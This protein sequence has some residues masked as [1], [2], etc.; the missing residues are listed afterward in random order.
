MALPDD[1]EL[2]GDLCR[3]RMWK[4]NSAGK[5]QIEGK[6]EIQVA[7]SVHRCRRCDRSG[8]HPAEVGVS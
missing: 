7:G 3:A 4:M 1:D 6:D 2:I 8:L 5:I